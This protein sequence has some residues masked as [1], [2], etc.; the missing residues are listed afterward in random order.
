MAWLVGDSH[1]ISV[2]DAAQV[3][4]GAAGLDLAVWTRSSC[5]LVLQ[6][7]G[8]DELCNE[9]RRSAFDAID[10]AHP[11]V[12]ILV[13]RAPLGPATAVAD[14]VAGLDNAL[15]HF[16]VQSIP[17]VLFGTGVIFEFSPLYTRSILR[18]EGAPA[19][20]ELDDLRAQRAD[21]DAQ[22][23]RLLGRHTLIEYLDPLE[24][25][26][27]ELCPAFDDGV[28]LYYDSHHISPQGSQRLIEP[29]R[30]AIEAALG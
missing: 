1:A 18:P 16:Q 24:S 9:W 13:N 10:A 30:A 15:H 4:A 28:W 21:L 8:P 2:A 29:L 25:M 19:A 26:C 14:Y 6:D 11:D 5:G 23:A 22:L 20:L 27:T 7:D 12:V 17:V 3:S